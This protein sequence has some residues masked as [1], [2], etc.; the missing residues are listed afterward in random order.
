VTAAAIDKDKDA[1]H[2]ASLG[3][4]AAAKAEEKEA[5]SLRR[6]G[7]DEE[8]IE[9]YDHARDLYVDT[10]LA[11]HDRGESDLADE[12][13]RAIERCNKIRS[14][15]RHPKETRAPAT[16]PRPNCLGCGKPL[17]R[18]KWDEKAFDD[19]T[20]REW[21]DYGDNRFCGL[22]CGWNWACRRAPMPIEADVARDN[23]RA[24]KGKK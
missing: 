21:G 22:R 8:A 2:A 7:R 1:R 18:F 4:L 10:D 13:K 5:R 12:V 15:I 17:R 16:T 11:F 14:N 24:T 23:A 3:K 20:P 9:S 19:G 6:E